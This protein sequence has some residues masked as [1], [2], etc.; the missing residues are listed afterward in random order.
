[1][2]YCSTPQK[3]SILS[4]YQMFSSN[5]REEMAFLHQVE[6]I[7]VVN[8]TRQPYAITIALN[9]NI[10]ISSNSWCFSLSLTTTRVGRNRRFTT[11]TMTACILKNCLLNS[12]SLQSKSVKLPDDDGNDYRTMDHTKVREKG[13]S[14]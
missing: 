6:I 8:T 12:R 11:R 1:M 14:F 10:R 9:L 13:T 3:H 7:V 4:I 5:I 2:C